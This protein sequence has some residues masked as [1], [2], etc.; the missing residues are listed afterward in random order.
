M[1]NIILFFLIFQINAA[2]SAEIDAYRAYHFST[3]GFDINSKH[4]DYL[5]N[6][7]LKKGDE[8]T[9]KIRVDKL[10]KINLNRDDLEYVIAIGFPILQNA[11]NVKNCEAL[12]SFDNG[13]SWQKPIHVEEYHSAFAATSGV[14]ANAIVFK[15][16]ALSNGVTTAILKFIALE[17]DIKAISGMSTGTGFHLK[18]TNQ[19]LMIESNN[20]LTDFG[21]HRL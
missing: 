8:L 11:I 13:V 10:A 6:V 15:Q 17:D 21:I 3:D 19:F 16:Y 20:Y 18:K 4:F 12:M 9:T 1:R 7:Q 2:F 14:N 5:T